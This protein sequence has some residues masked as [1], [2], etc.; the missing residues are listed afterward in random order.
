[1]CAV[2]SEVVRKTAYCLWCAPGS[3]LGPIL[4][5]LYVN[6]I[7]SSVNSSK[8]LLYADDTV[9]LY[10]G[11]SV[12]DI[13]NV[14]TE[15]LNS[16]TNW[17]LQNKLHLNTKKCKWTLFGSKRRL[18]RVTLPHISIQ[19][20]EIEHVTSYKY[21]GVHLDQNLNFEEHVDKI[22]SK[23]RQRLGVLRRVRGFVNQETALMLYNALV[24]PLIDY[25]DVTYSLCTKKCI[26]KVD[27]LMLKG[28]KIVLGVPFDTPGI[29]VLEKLKWMSFQERSTFHKCMQM[30]K[31]LHKMTPEYLGLRFKKIDHGYNTRQ[32][33]LNLKVIKCGTSMGQRAFT[34]DGAVL[35]NSLPA[36]MK[37]C[38][39]LNIFKNKL[40]IHILN[41]RHFTL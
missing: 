8:I 41:S 13:I 18:N 1:M 12:S 23:V 24:M 35:W 20:E 39:S 27:K 6:D 32:S 2:W 21:L 5:I 16:I 19:N 31:C 30:Y 37:D 36:E 22:C 33:N 38:S 28:G 25:C 9:L 10:S 26:K 4:F 7:I 17:F 40:L 3:I 34:Y 15:D 11:K 29:T 14:L